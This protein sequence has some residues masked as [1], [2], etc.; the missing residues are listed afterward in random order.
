MAPKSLLKTLK[1]KPQERL[2]VV[3]DDVAN[4]ENLDDIV[5]GQDPPGAP[6]LPAPSHHELAAWGRAR[7]LQTSLPNGN[8]T[9][10]W[11]ARIQQM[12]RDGRLV[13]MAGVWYRRGA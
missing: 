1:H 4:P 11:P 10:G 13:S 2:V 12:I 5:Y 6:R 7:A 8:P 9:E 3:E